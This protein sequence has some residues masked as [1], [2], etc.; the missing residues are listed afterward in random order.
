M[1]S[2]INVGELIGTN[3]VE[4][5]RWLCFALIVFPVLTAM[6]VS[7]ISRSPE[8]RMTRRLT[9]KDNDEQSV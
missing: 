3:A 9:E 1:L 5:R 6:W 2:V 7:S 4:S 8:E